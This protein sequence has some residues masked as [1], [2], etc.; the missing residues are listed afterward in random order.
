MSVCVFIAVIVVVCS[1]W[2]GLVLITDFIELWTR[3]VR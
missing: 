3:K 1:G 2:G